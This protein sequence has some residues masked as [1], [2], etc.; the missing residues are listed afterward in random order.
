VMVPFGIAVGAVT[1]LVGNQGGVAFGALK[2][3]RTGGLA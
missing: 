2:E 3:R 1:R